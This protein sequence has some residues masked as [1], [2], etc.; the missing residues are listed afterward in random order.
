MRSHSSFALLTL[1]PEPPKLISH[2]F[3]VGHQESPSTYTGPS[4]PELCAEK[5][6]PLPNI[7]HSTP[8][9]HVSPHLSLLFN[10]NTPFLPLKYHARYTTPTKLH[11]LLPSPRYPNPNLPNWKTTPHFTFTSSH[12]TT[13]ISNN[14]AKLCIRRHK[15]HLSPFTA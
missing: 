3:V 12:A 1:A 13:H 9:L 15:S 8:Q 5:S 11:P 14:G 10:S 6:P 2:Y 7:V 4:R